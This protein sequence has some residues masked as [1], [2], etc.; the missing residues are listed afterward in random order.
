MWSDELRSLRRDV[1][2]APVG[3]TGHPTRVVT[4]SCH[5]VQSSAAPRASA[6]RVP[7]YVHR[8][9]AVVHRRRDVAASLGSQFASAAS[10]SVVRTPDP[11]TRRPGRSSRPPRRRQLGRSNPGPEQLPGCNDRRAEVEDSYHP[12]AGGPQGLVLPVRHWRADLSLE[13]HEMGLRQPIGEPVHRCRRQRA[14]RHALRR[15][16]SGSAVFDNTTVIQRLNTVGGNAP[17]TPG[18]VVGAVALRGIVRPPRA[19]I[20]Q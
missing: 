18:S 13:W 4:R 3:H 6:R 2:T 20:V 17:S 10:A 5:L 7:G 9:C 15:P 16:V 1:Q 12:V 8:L 11:R 19:S 14:G